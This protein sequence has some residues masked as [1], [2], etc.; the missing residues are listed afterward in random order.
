[1]SVRRWLVTSLAFLPSLA[2]FFH[3]TDRATT[4]PARAFGVTPDSVRRVRRNR[5]AVE[6]LAERVYTH[7]CWLHEQGRHQLLAAANICGAFTLP[8][9]AGFE[10]DAFP[11][12]GGV[13]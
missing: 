9:P 2:S 3:H 1:M 7:W 12:A 8:K 6:H 11:Y 5:Q 13:P 4:R 10:A